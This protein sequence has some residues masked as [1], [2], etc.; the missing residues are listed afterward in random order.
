VHKRIISA[1]KRVCDRMSYIIVRGRWCH[2]IVKN[3][4]APTEHKIDYVKSSFYKELECVFNKFPKYHTKTS[5]YFNAKVG[6][7]DIFKPT[8]TGN[9]R[10]HK[11]TNDN[12]VTAVN[13]A[14]SK[15]FTINSKMFPHHNNHKYT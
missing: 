7:E 4:H 15:N 8:T 3:V 12:G 13:F 14:I 9:K 11:I 2:I 6:S 10:L 1:V 5:L